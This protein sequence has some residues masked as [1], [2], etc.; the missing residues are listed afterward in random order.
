M[1]RILI[2]VYAMGLSANMVAMIRT[3]IEDEVLRA[4]VSLALSRVFKA[5]LYFVPVEEADVEW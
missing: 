3:N 4:A 2:F 1:V 5:P